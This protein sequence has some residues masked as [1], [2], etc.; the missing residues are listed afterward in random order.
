MANQYD[1]LGTLFVS[2]LLS[3]INYKAPNVNTGRTT[4]AWKTQVAHPS[5]I[6]LAATQA[7]ALHIIQ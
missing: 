5:M 4:T 3:F 6:S 1:S 7:H 2:F